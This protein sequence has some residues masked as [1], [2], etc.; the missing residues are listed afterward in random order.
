MRENVSRGGRAVAAESVAQKAWS[1]EDI[2]LLMSL[3]KEGWSNPEIAKRLDR[4]RTAVATKFYDLTE[5]DERL[6]KR[7]SPATRKKVE[8][9]KPVIKENVIKCLK[10]RKMFESRG[11]KYNR[12]CDG[13]KSSMDWR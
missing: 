1:K 12:V 9:T 10:C 6:R 3:K 5:R 8:Y 11:V 13:C 2:K 4:S 7:A